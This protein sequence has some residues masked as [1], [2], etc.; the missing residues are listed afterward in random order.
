MVRKIKDF[1]R[2]KFPATTELYHQFRLLLLSII[3][4]PLRL[5]VFIED[6]YIRVPIHNPY[7]YQLSIGGG[8]ITKGRLYYE[9]VLIKTTKEMVRGKK[10]LFDVGAH[11]GYWSYIAASLGMTVVAFEPI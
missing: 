7:V 1:L 8:R 6:T 5:Y 9:E 2:G 3:N 4:Y 10:V 11:I